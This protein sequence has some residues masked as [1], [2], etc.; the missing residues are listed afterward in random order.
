MQLNIP[1]DQR[2]QTIADALH[3]VKFVQ[4]ES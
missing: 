2:N 3:I 4:S 1:R